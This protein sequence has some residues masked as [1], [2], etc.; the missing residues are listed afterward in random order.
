MKRQKEITESPVIK[1]Q[2]EEIDLMLDFMNI[3]NKCEVEYDILVTE[4]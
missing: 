1:F 4:G 3:C 2:E